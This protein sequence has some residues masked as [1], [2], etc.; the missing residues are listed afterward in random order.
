MCRWL[1]YQGEPI[2][3]ETL[4]YQP[5][6]SLIQQSLSAR[7]GATRVNADGFGIGWYSNRSTP[8]VFHEVMPAWSDDNL[9][10]L[11][12][13]LSSHRFMAHVRASTG[14]Q[15]SRANCH[16]FV[17]NQWMFIH[18]GQIG[19]YERLRYSLERHLSEKWYQYRT[20]T[21]DS[22]LIF[23]LMLQNGLQNDPVLAI[24]KTLE[25]ILKMIE[26]KQIS[27][28]FKASMC[29]SDGEQIWIVRYS[30]DGHAPTVFW[31][32]DGQNVVFSSEPL[33]SQGK[34]RL[35][36]EHCIMQVKQDRVTSTPLTVRL[37]H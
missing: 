23:L 32:Q 6:F 4:I 25:T 11:A 37:T 18:N 28:P 36:N 26:D 24:E 20:G 8:G 21:T 10:S 5:E 15:V 31:Q 7:K 30:S 17:V 2:Y 19:D 3:L 29:L 34:W 9:R 22:E 13:H 33:C 14:T 12:H 35:I 1:A 16:P 27:S